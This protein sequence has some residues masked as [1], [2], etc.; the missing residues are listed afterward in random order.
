MAA[1][2]AG[3]GPAAL[4]GA[5]APGGETTPQPVDTTP[6]TLQFWTRFNFL[7]G[8]AALYNQGPGQQKKNT[9]EYVF[10]PGGEMVDKLVAAI[11][12]GA[13]PDVVS[14]DLIQNPKFNASG[15]FADLTGRYGRLRY[16]DE[17]SR[18]MLK[19]GEYQ[20]KQY[21]LPFS[22]DNSAVY[23]NKE[24]FAQVG[25]DPEKG[26]ETWA[27]YVEYARK[28]TRPPDR[29]GTRLNVRSGGGYM[30]TFLPWVWA[31]GGDVLNADGTKCAFNTPP[32]IEALE[33]WVD[34]NQKHRVTPEQNRTGDAY[35]VNESFYAGQ[36]AMY[37]GGNAAIPTHKRQAPQLQFNTGLMPKPKA[38]GRTA[39]FAG[40]DNIGIP[41]ATKHLDRAWDV[42]QYFLS[43]EVQIEYLAKQGVIPVRR[44]F[45]EN[46]YFRDEPRFRTFTRSLDVAKAPWTLKYNE[47]F[48]RADSPWAVNLD[49]AM[50][51]QKPPKQAAQDIEREIN[52]ILAQ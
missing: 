9:V 35:N 8:A 44:D 3:V 19:L 32:A 12:G 29:Y 21:Q 37:L 33:A 45:Y 24:L 28:L 48:Q 27:D 50:F 16:K 49:A 39:S 15:G 5:C 42:L 52:A 51:G 46:R 7:E 11:T 14:L 10:V 47:S 1:G 18:A 43:E 40:G 41:A 6:A 25:L 20:S 13:P 23:W 34:M 31:N 2:A 36:L 17:L 22:S 30:F 38:G 4:L 26:P